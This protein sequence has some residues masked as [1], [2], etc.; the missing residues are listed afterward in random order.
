MDAWAPISPEEDKGVG[1]PDR[2]SIP[3][4]AYIVMVIAAG[5]ALLAL[6][7][8]ERLGSIS[9]PYLAILGAACAVAAL[10]QVI[11][12]EGSTAKTSYNLGL[13]VYGF[14]LVL[15]GPGAALL[16]AVFACLMD[17]AWNRYPWF[18]QAFNICCLIV[19]LSVA[20]LV[21]R[22]V[23]GAASALSWRGALAMTA[24][25]MC[26]VIL[27]HIMVGLAIVF[28]R[29]ESFAQSGVF[30]KISLLMDVTLFA[31]GSMAGLL[32]LSSPYLVPLLLIPLYMLSATL[33]VPSL[34]RQAVLDAKTGLHN[35]RYFHEALDRE[36]A[37]A[38][39]LN[40]PLCVI[41]AD[42]DLLR[43]INNTYG[44]LAGDSVL[45]GIARIFKENFREHDIVARFGGEEFSILMPD[46]LL[47]D[48]VPRVERLRRTIQSTYF[49]SS[50]LAEPVKA[51]MSFGIAQR[52]HDQNAQEI[53]HRADLALYQAKAEGRN[54]VRVALD[55]GS[56]DW[57]QGDSYL[58][59]LEAEEGDSAAYRVMV[60]EIEGSAPAG[61]AAAAADS[62]AAIEGAPAA[63]TAADGSP[64]DGSPST[65]NGITRNGSPGSGSPGWRVAAVASAVILA[66][67]VAFW[68]SLNALGSF[69]LDWYKLGLLAAIAALTELLS[70]EIYVR[71]TSVS[72]SA[73]P[74]VAAAV[75][76]GPLGVLVMSIAM[77]GPAMIK[78]RSSP[79]RFF[80]NTG[81][82]LLAGLG[83]VWL[84]QMTPVSAGSSSHWLQFAL[85]IV[86]A[87]LLFGITT[88][89][90]STVLSI[91]SKEQVSS[92]WKEKFS[93]LALYYLGLGI[94]AAAIVLGY[95]YL[96]YLGVV[97]AL[98]PLFILRWAQKEYVTRTK[99]LV[100][101]LR[102]SNESLTVRAAEV[103]E[104]NEGL[105][106][107]LAKAVELRDP[108]VLGHSQ[109]VAR[110]AIMLARELHL[111]EERIELIRKAALLH[112]IGKVGI[113]DH[114]LFKP[115]RLT[116]AEYEAVKAHPEMATEV[117]GACRCLETIATIVLHHH[118]R[119]DGRGYP[120]G[121]TG[122]MI[123]LESRILAVADALEAIT[124]GR[125]YR[126]G[127]AADVALKEIRDNVG[128]QFD[129]EVV[130]ALISVTSRE[131]ESLI[132][133]SAAQVHPRRGAV[134][135]GGPLAAARPRGVGPEP[136]NDPACLPAT[137]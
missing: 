135:D 111:P 1:N 27:N 92:I 42:L 14:T 79:L 51:T 100:A 10:A 71:E 87:G 110:Y 18:I 121:L 24:A 36:L 17:W 88:T 86:G 75:L 84:V 8:V 67:T 59:G 32:W 113:E 82:H 19:N 62:I 48:A 81:S 56:L 47:A 124:S 57:V 12:V 40:R 54:R 70:V 98:A 4:Q 115:G 34:E 9:V 126:A 118:E 68:L 132:V 133:D 103:T 109:N 129:P 117:L 128:R 26:F 90:V 20:G 137:R 33:R 15:L 102:E 72:T 21:F 16:V 105:L 78:H 55:R 22:G 85:S 66:A 29:G 39:R 41:V 37:R 64:V 123:P 122:L 43:S 131:D 30:G 95:E 114:I 91:S 3:A 80:F 61:T 106:G 65:S 25:A 7:P 101:A 130:A 50:A 94:V 11:K 2:L 49:K 89:L 120:D 108:F 53:L 44:H 5:G 52:T 112:D 136:G 58:E 116:P 99:D 125:P 76:F 119:Y 97:L 107:A 93:W 13:L 28:A 104:L 63:H 46:T 74:F 35:A 31:S 83:T 69:D 134:E 127:S 45:T 38:N 6:M 96:G 77:A 73:A 23:V 60:S